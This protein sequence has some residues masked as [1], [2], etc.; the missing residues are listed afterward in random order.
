MLTLLSSCATTLYYEGDGKN[1]P[2]VL[3]Q[4]EII[5]PY[6]SLGRIQ[7]ELDLYIAQ[8]QELNDW[9][10]RAL[11]EEAVKM[12]ADAVMFPEI[13]S[14]PAPHLIIPAQTYRAVGVAIRF[15]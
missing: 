12:G 11:Q 15:K 8:I 4:D 5:R 7:I 3:S 10:Y 9:G 13:S 6:T 2:P 14:K 1:L